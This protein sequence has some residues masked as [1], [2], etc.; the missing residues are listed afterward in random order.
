MI[1]KCKAQLSLFFSFFFNT[2]KRHGS[3]NALCER[4][5]FKEQFTTCDPQLQKI[6]LFFSCNEWHLTV[7]P[8]KVQ[9]FLRLLTHVTVMKYSR[10]YFLCYVTAQKKGR[11]LWHIIYN[12]L[13]ELQCIKQLKVARLFTLQSWVT[14]LEVVTTGFESQQ[15]KFTSEQRKREADY[16]LPSHLIHVHISGLKCASVGVC[17]CM[18]GCVYV[19]VRVCVCARARAC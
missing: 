14:Y 7:F 15:Y 2:S 1:M 10:D 19:C 4:P 16:V 11:I 9:A 18:R 6:R 12:S 17:V 3:A 13:H 8:S 5:P